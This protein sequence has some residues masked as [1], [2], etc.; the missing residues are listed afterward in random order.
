VITFSAKC[1]DNQGNSGAYTTG[2]IYDCIDGNIKDDNGHFIGR[3]FSKVSELNNFS[4]S[5][6][7]EVGVPVEEKYAEMVKENEKMEMTKSK[8]RSGD[9]VKFKNGEYGIVMKDTKIPDSQDIG[10]IFK[11]ISGFMNGKSYNDTLIKT[12]SGT[13]FEIIAV[14]ER[15]FNIPDIFDYSKLGK[16]KWEFEEE[17]E[18]MT[19]SEICKAL[20]KAN[21]KI[22]KER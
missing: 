8:L 12:T 4:Y 16:L 18:E 7:S 19:I 20:G 6:W 5:V 22:V 15:P 9:R 17:V 10:I 13:E 11:T 2:K 3:K 14:Y 1:T 21:I